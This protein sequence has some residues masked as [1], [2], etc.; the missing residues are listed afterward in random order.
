[1]PLLD[2]DEIFTEPLF[3]DSFSVI[4]TTQT[5]NSSGQAQFSAATIS[6]LSGVVTSNPGHD[7]QRLPDGERQSEKIMV[8]TEF[9]L[10]TGNGSID[11]DQVIWNGATYTVASVEDYSRYGSGFVKATCYFLGT[12]E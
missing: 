11:A 12:S 3:I 1:M 8:A 2:F 6:G 9:A 7:L 10:T 4:R 5:V